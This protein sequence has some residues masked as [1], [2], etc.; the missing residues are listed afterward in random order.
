MNQLAWCGVKIIVLRNQPLYN[1]RVEKYDKTTIIG[2]SRFATIKAG[3]MPV[4]NLCAY[5]GKALQ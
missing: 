3:A 4:I 2:L 1:T 5:I